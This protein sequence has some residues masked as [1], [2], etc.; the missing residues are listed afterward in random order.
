MLAHYQPTV[1][2]DWVE[3]KYQSVGILTPADLTIDNIANAFHIKVILLPGAKEEALWD[4]SL[5]A[6]FLNADKPVLETREI[7]FHELCHPL[8]HHGDQLGMSSH[9][10]LHQEEQA[11]HFQLYA[12]LPFF[13]IR[14]LTLPQLEQDIIH[15]LATEFA[16]THELAR[17]RWEQIHRRNYSGEAHYQLVAEIRSRY[18]K[19]LPQDWSDETKA[20]YE[21]AIQRQQKHYRGMVIR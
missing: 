18:K 14:S 5:A 13:M 8:L 2:E 3:A 12:A 1:L 15:L 19:S 20:L 10:R 11:G 16:V 9:Q 17:R 21:R 6:I 7:F 4:D